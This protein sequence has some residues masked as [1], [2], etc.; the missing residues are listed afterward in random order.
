VKIL[1]IFPSRTNATPNDEL[2]RF[3]VPGFFDPPE[4]DEIHISVTFTWDIKRAREL[5]FSWQQV[6]PVVRIGGPALGDPGGE[7]VS[8]RY[9]K[10]GCVITSR[11][12]INHCSYC[13]AQKREG[14]IRTLP[15]P[16]GFNIMDN[17]ILAT[18][19]EH[20]ESVIEMLRKQKQKAIFTGGL[21]AGLLTQWHADQLRSTMP[22][23][24][25]FANDRPGDLEKLQ[26]ASAKMFN[27][28][29]TKRHLYCYVLI[30]YK[31][32]TVPEAEKRLIATWEAGFMPYA[33]LFR[34]EQGETRYVEW[35]RFQR[36]WTRPAI[37]RNRMKF[38][39]CIL[40]QKPV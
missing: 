31:N 7:F 40:P 21:E 35:K 1:R 26:S 17:N 32:D 23:R 28:G 30:G 14:Y 20:F 15:I 22:E 39:P 24:L 9:L 16:E 5:Y 25:Y 37:V 11:G 33:M 18:P 3:D 2:C 38:T 34:N 4:C 8:G 29:F 13:M 12:C 10:P 6:H 27:A 36:L 19:I